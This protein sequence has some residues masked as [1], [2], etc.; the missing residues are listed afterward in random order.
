M[1]STSPNPLRLALPKGRMQAGVLRLLDE[2]G[3]AVTPS[4][5][6]Y[7]PT[8]SLSGIEA[9]LLK[10]QNIIEMLA[11]GSRDI[12]FAGADWVT[13]LEAEVVELVD[14]DLDP[15]TLVAAAPSSLL[16]ASG[17]LPQ[18]ALVV[19]SEYPRLAASWIRGRELDARFVRSYGATEV[20]PPED[21]DVIIDNSATGETLRA[22]GLE[23]LDVLARSSTRLLASPAALD[24]PGRRSRIEDLQLLLDSVLAARQRVLVEVNAPSDRLEA[25]VALL[26]SMRQPTVSPLFGEAG[27]AVKAA[28]PRR[29]LPEIVPALKAAGATDVVVSTPSQIVP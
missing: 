3:L 9:K 23:V 8:V 16:D 25:I 24:D 5:R 22:N 19:A 13:E 2:A 18:R 1:P 28:V 17:A 26:P 14:T 27:H 11:A 6:S 15:V 20:F 7:R 12:G 10:P 4:A 21:A 29:R